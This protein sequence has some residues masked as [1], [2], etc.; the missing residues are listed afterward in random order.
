MTHPQL[1]SRTTGPESEMVMSQPCFP[2]LPPF[3][4]Q[5]W[6]SRLLWPARQNGW[7]LKPMVRRAPTLLPPEKKDLG[8]CGMGISICGETLTGTPRK[9]ETSARQEELS[10]QLSRP[11]THI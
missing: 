2:I 11:G 1:A 6:K 10:R 4:S 8:N 3:P 5:S 9:P 7:G